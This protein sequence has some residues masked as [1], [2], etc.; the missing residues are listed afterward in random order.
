MPANGRHRRSKVKHHDQLFCFL[1]PFV[2]YAEADDKAKYAN[3]EKCEQDARNEGYHVR[4][5][6]D[7]QHDALIFIL[8]LLG[9]V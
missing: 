6:A 1:L 8:V 9:H 2:L 7:I 5:V 4:L 3:E